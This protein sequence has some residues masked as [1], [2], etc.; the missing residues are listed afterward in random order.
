MECVRR[1]LISVLNTRNGKRVFVFVGGARH[2]PRKTRHAI[3][4]R[5]NE[6]LNENK[7]KRWKPLARRFRQALKRKEVSGKTDRKTEKLAR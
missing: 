4:S 1:P 5:L 3:H 7:P 6:N 2:I